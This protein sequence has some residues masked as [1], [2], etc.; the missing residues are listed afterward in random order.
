LRTLPAQVDAHQRP[1]ATTA[2]QQRIKDLVMPGSQYTSIALAETLVLGGITAS[3]GSIGGAYNNALAETTIGLLKTEAVGR[4]RP[5]LAGPLR[6]I[7]DVE[8]TTMEWVDYYNTPTA[9]P[10]QLH[11][12]RRIR[13]LLLR[14]NPGVPDAPS[15]GGPVR[16]AVGTEAECSSVAVVPGLPPK[17]ART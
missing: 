12:T 10:A 9:Q 3:I 1:G 11:L 4:R 16:V 2:E 6:T 8:Y 14:S 5:F 7:D 15:T 17:Q 13:D